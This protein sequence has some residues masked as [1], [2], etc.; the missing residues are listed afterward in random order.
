[1]KV[2]W[3][4]GRANPPT[5]GHEK[6]FK[7]VNLEAS[8]RS[9]ESMIF[10]SETQDKKKNPLSYRDKVNVVER[11]GFKVTKLDGVKTPFQV[12][13]ELAKKGYTEQ[14]MVVGQDRVQEFQ[15][16]MNKYAE[17]YGV[18]LEVISAGDR[19]PDA[20]GTTG[21][22]GTKMREYAEN[23]NFVS[24]RKGLI[25]TMPLPSAESVFHLVRKAL[26]YL[27]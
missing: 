8:S 3:T 5:K 9:A 14:T 4:F 23:N 1:M 18:R 6:L 24:F 21:I 17:Q 15:S 10:L 2:V 26:G 12:L 13:E 27:K 19:D 22:S 7:K 16:K 20:E 11:A 25:G